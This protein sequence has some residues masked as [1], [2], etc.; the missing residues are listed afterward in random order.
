MSAPVDTSTQELAAT[1]EPI[2]DTIP[3]PNETAQ[4]P[5]ETEAQE[6]EQVQ[7]FENCN[8]T[9]YATGTINIWVSYTAYS[10]KY[11]GNSVTRTGTSI[12][13]TKAEVWS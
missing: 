11:K 3:D 6:V 10:E 7:L 12:A 13:G 4:P 2:K 5:E 9:V 8:E 1:P